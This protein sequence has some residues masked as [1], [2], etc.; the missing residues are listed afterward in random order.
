ML[1]KIIQVILLSAIFI[2]LFYGLNINKIDLDKF[3]LVGIVAT[4][5]VIFMS[6]LVL[7]LRWMKMSD[8][9][10]MVSFETIIVSSALN[11]ILP[12]K[13]GELSKA[14]Y[15]KKFYKYNYHKTLSIIFME[16][17]F[18][19]IMLFL[20]LC[21]WAYNYASSDMM[22]SAL[23]MLSLFIVVIIFF[24]NTTKTLQ[25]LKKIPLQFLRIYLQ[26]IYK[27]VHRMFQ[28]PFSLSFYTVVL[29][30]VYFFGTYVFF[31]YA[32]D[33]N[34]NI[35]VI[36]GLF[37]FSTI[38]LSLPLAPAGI[39]TYEAAVVFYLSGYGISKGDALFAATLYHILLFLVD[40]LLLYFFL[41]FK[42]IKLKE[43]VK[44]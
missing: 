40:F 19:M 26:K 16:R 18:D 2:Y 44:Q 36:L 15:L 37:I 27:V 33:F 1:N 43:L 39:G 35:T 20:L 41:L 4:F 6:Q 32:V 25:L 9:S 34:L 30:L 31:T 7:S 29:W 38:A 21:I 42:D 10:F 24:F 8:L 23:L 28:S 13:L 17:F 22:K 5:F 12:A 14:F 11:M 3:S